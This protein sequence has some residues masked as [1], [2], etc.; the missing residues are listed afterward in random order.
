MLRNTD[1]T[2]KFDFVNNRTQP[3]S[4]SELAEEVKPALK[5][6]DTRLAENKKKVGLTRQK[7]KKSVLTV[8]K[9]EVK[10][11]PL[12]E[13]QIREA[14]SKL[15]SLDQHDETRLKTMERRNFLESF[16]IDKNE[17][18]EGKEALAVMLLFNLST[19]RKTK[20]INVHLLLN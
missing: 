2:V 16:L 15:N 18:L 1:G 9:D 11:L 8:H 14:R 20:E 13:A 17:W 5:M 12:T 19:L 4:Q 7:I 6:N 3:L 10:P